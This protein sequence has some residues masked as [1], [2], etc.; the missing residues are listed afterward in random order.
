MRLLVT[1]NPEWLVP[2]GFEERRFATLDIGEARIQ[3]AEYF[4]AIDAE[5]DNG[6]R[7]ALLDFL[8]HFDL[9]SV[10]LR[11]IPKTSALLDQKLSSLS[12]E[13]GWW[14][15]TLARGELPWGV[16]EP[17]R[18]PAFRL[19]DRYVRHASRHGARRRAIETQL[20]R[21]LHKHV[22]GLVK[23]EGSY[24]HW[25]G[26]EMIYATG[27][28]YAFPPL[29]ECREAFAK[30]LQQKFKWV[31]KDGWSVEPMP[32]QEPREGPF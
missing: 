7:E 26:F 25:K 20:G 3:D 17:A 29:A 4:A 18:C 8:L 13:H 12:P 14:L 22:P 1:G 24:M 32:D 21:F 27:A 19:F 15:D 16:E 9:T 31:E 6:G 30:M 28:V 2:A 10:D 5:M 23:S 11:A